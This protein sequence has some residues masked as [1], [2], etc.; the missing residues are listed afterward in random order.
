[1]ILGSQL[2]YVQPCSRFV[3]DRVLQ[4]LR[5]RL[6]ATPGSSQALAVGILVLTG[7]SPHNKQP[8]SCSEDA[9]TVHN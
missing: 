4:S 2:C 8:W 6:V 9:V 1:M 3:R 5:R 7:K